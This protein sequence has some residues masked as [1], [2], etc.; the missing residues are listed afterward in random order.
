MRKG[1]HMRLGIFTDPHYST[2]D[3]TC[4]VRNNS[5]SLDKICEA[6]RLFERL[7]CDHAV[8][9]GDLTDS[10]DSHEKEIENLK[11]IKSV[12]SS[13]SVPTVCLM[14]NHDAFSFTKDEFYGILGEDFIPADH[15]IGGKKLLFLDACYFKSGTQYMPGDSD[16]SD[17]YYPFE[18]NLKETVSSGKEDIFVFIHQNLDPSAPEPFRI[19]NEKSVNSILS[20]CGKVK[21]VFQG[22]YHPGLVNEVNGIRYVTFPAMCEHEGAYFTEDI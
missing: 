9:L 16:W 11:E 10:E 20:E 5:K 4:G 8:C 12:I 21:A 18:D 22:H 19:F 14:G 2:Q 15:V 17:S 3:V 6:Y 13:F 1:R 7:N